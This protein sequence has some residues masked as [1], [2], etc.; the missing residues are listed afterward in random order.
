MEEMLGKT[1]GGLPNENHLTL[2]RHWAQGG[3]GM[4]ITG[5]NRARC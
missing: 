5:E 1:G 3:W 4:L 2:Y